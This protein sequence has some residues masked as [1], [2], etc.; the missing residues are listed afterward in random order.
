MSPYQRNRFLSVPTVICFV[1]FL[2]VLV[3]FLTLLLSQVKPEAGQKM[4]SVPGRLS[5][6]WNQLWPSTGSWIIIWAFSL[7]VFVLPWS[8]FLRFSNSKNV[9]SR[10]DFCPSAL[11]SLQRTMHDLEKTNKVKNSF[12]ILIFV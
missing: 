7:L 12:F 6:I 1:L 2:L 3:A 10:D 4:G 9:C 8:A 11:K 5:V